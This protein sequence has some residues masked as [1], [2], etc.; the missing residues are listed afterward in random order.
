MSICV[1][2]IDPCSHMFALKIPLS[3]RCVL[4][5]T[6]LS[7]L[8]CWHIYFTSRVSSTVTVF[9]M[10]TYPILDTCSTRIMVYLHPLVFNLPVIWA[11]NSGVGDTN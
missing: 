2:C 1:V 11:M 3:A 9:Y 5:V 6:P 4:M 7:K 10:Y 8:Y